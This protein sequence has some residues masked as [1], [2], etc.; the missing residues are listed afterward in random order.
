M[1]AVVGAAATAG[2]ATPTLDE[3]RIAFTGMGTFKRSAL[4]VMTAGLSEARPRVLVRGSRR[5]I[6]PTALSPVAWSADGSRIAFAASQGKRHGIYTVRVDGT[7]LRFLHGT[8]GGESPV[9]SPDGT[10]IAFAREPLRGYLFG[11]LT[12][13]VANAD[14]SGAH[15]LADWRAGVEY[16]PSSFSPDGSS[17]AVTKTVSGSDRS[18]ALL[19]KLDRSGGVRVLARR[20]SEPV[21]SPD[22]SQVV[23]VRHSISRRWKIEIVHRDLAVASADGARNRLL[24][25]TR[26]VA[27]SHP[28]WES[29]GQR[30][31]FNSFRIS[32]DPIEALFDELLPFGNSIVQINV[33]G[34]CR[35]KVL[36]ATDAALTGAAWQP[37]LASEMGRIAC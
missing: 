32:K 31:A 25:R 27:E 7:G 26:W 20:A 1:L 23:F 34:T 24:T 9:F 13:W 30:I 21:F 2:A 22:G 16:H 18:T 12:P 37:G 8:R 11:A 5:G 29:S 35:Q 28:S 19:L 17:L 14:G 36:S 4:T 3:S 10:K 6:T 33:D 15:R